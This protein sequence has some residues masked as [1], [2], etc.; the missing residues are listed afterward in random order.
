[1][2]AFLYIWRPVVA[3]VCWEVGREVQC[4]TVTWWLHLFPVVYKQNFIFVPEVYAN[5]LID[6]FCVLNFFVCAEL[7]WIISHMDSS[8]IHSYETVKESHRIQPKM[9]QKWLVK[10][11]LNHSSAQHWDIWEPIWQKAFSCLKS[12]Q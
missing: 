12:H 8:F 2:N 3:S 9:V 6:D 7:L 4:S 5:T 1:L 10:Q 11:A